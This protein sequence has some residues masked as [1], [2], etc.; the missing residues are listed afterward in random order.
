M[1]DKNDFIDE[2]KVS[3]INKN[4]YETENSDDDIS[5]SNHLDLS[6][7]HFDVQLQVNNGQLEQAI[8]YGVFSSSQFNDLNIFKINQYS[9]TIEPEM[10]MDDRDGKRSGNFNSY[11]QSYYR[12]NDDGSY[13]RNRQTNGSS[14]NN[15]GSSADGNGSNPNRNNNNNN[16]SRR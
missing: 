13:R 11:S 8:R 3:L 14:G 6:L 7:N 10:D 12:N 2:K 4:T 5:I 15:G 9:Q 16:N 1:N